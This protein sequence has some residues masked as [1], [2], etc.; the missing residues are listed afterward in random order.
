[1]N[2]AL[3]GWA[4]VHAESYARCLVDLPDVALIAI[5]DRGGRERPHWAGPGV[6]VA[7]TLEEALASAD[8]VV[9]ASANSDHKE[10]AIAAA[11]AGRHVLCEKPLAATVPDAMAIIDAARE[12]GIVL[13]TA[14]PVR[15]VP[16]VTSAW[17]AVRA[18]TYGRILALSGANNGQVPDPAWFTD[19]ALAGGGAVMDHTVHLA[20]LMRWFLQDEVVEIYAEIDTLLHDIRVDDVGVLSVRFAGGAIGTIDA[21]WNRPPEYPSWGGLELRIVAEG[22]V[23]DLD[24]FAQR[25]TVYGRRG[26]AWVDWGTDANRA[27]LQAFGRACRGEPTL[28]ASGEDG[29]EALKF[30]RMAYESAR[31]GAPVRAA[32]SNE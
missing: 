30:V 20:D 7:P 12:A 10:L 4:H 17:R 18:G 21:S 14:F 16:A 26:A 15:F 9:I 27:M 22:G 29:L 19:P 6:R 24:P 28:L 5:F 13:A 8:A 3:L 1:M 32:F 31:D 11:R 2:I 23:I 25:L